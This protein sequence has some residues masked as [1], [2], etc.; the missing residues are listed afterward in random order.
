MAIGFNRERKHKAQILAQ[1][2]PLAWTIYISEATT[3]ANCQVL[4]RG[5]AF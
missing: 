4:G 2:P 5:R 3:I 1:V